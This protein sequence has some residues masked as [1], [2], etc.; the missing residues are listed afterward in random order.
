MPFSDDATKLQH[1][2]RER[3]ESQLNFAGFLV[4]HCPLKEDAVATLRMLADSSHRVGSTMCSHF[5]LCLTFCAQC[6][7][8][9]GDNPLTAVH[10]AKEVEIVDRDALILDTREGA[11]DPTGQ[12]KSI[13]DVRWRMVCSSN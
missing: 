11:T 2:P 4:F 13:V 7:M 12:Y 10:V 1:L 9:T 3:V 8:I 6:I 5:L